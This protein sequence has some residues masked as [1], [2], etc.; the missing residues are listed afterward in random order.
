MPRTEIMRGIPE[1]QKQRIEDEYRAVGATTTW[2]KQD[3]LWTV[4][5]TIPDA[6]AGNGG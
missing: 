5:A 3:G 6:P 4:T 2:T 1:D